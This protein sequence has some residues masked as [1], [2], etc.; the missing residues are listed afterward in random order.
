MSAL[1]ADVLVVGGGPAGLSAALAARRKG[2]RV[3]V[4]DGNRPP[5]DKACGEG[6]MPDSREAAARIGVTIPDSCGYPFRGI[7]FLG[8]R[9]S[10]KADFP[11]GKGLGLRRTALHEI[12]AG[13][14]EQAGVDLRWGTPVTSLDTIRARWII[15]ADGSGSR[16]R[17][18]AGLDQYVHNSRRFAYRQHF[19]IAPWT[20]FMEIYWSRGCQMYITPTGANEICAALISRDPHLRVE[21]ALEPFF[22]ALHARLRGVPHSSRERG[23]VTSMLRLKNVTA[24]KVALIGDASGSVDA[25]T[26][27]GICLTFRQ[28]SLLADAIAGG[29]LSTYNEIHPRL[30]FRPNLMARLMLLM[31]RGPLIREGA[32]AGLANMPFLFRSLLAVHVGALE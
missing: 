2:L 16:V 9:H 21:Q 6:L 19:A 25:I 5:V 27:E 8:E 31:D 24:G 12:L 18:W 1:E 13:A 30:A 10:V 29:D 20:E 17:H 3:I 26:G 14:A 22:P 32:I 23:A 11:A 15:G 4:A 7:R 28:A